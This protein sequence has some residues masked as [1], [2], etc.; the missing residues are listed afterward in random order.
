MDPKESGEKKTVALEQSEKR[1]ELEE[2]IAQL[3]K[4]V[5]EQFKFTRTVIVLC[6]LVTIGLTIFTVLLTFESMPAQIT[7]YCMSNMEP[8]VKQWKQVEAAFE[9]QKA[10]SA[11]KQKELNK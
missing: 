4:R 9:A 10:R 8:I 7:F 11:A 1:T 2:Q 6:T 5:D 3:A